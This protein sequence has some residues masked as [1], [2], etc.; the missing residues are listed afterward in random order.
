MWVFLGSWESW[1][2]DKLSACLFRQLEVV[3]AQLQLAGL[4]TSHLIFIVWASK[5]LW[6][7]WNPSF[8]LF[9]LVL[10][11]LLFFLSEFLALLTVEKVAWKHAIYALVVLESER[12]QR[13]PRCDCRHR[14]SLF[15]KTLD[16]SLPCN[17][18]HPVIIILSEVWGL[19]TACSRWHS[20]SVI[21]EHAQSVLAI[22]CTAAPSH[23]HF[24]RAK[25]LQVLIV[26]GTV[27]SKKT[28]ESELC[29]S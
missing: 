8:H 25:L 23:G 1:M 4:I 20:R 28:K 21:Q 27:G 13:E 5:A 19:G 6:L 2:P 16:F 24:L 9:G 10:F 14:T 29:F 18:F 15:F 22:Y 11:F 7:G 17:S 12:K 26:F 3:G